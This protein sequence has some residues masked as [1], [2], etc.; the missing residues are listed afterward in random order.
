[1]LFSPRGRRAGRANLAPPS[2]FA[3]LGARGF[4]MAPELES[5]RPDE[6]D[7][8]PAAPADNSTTRSPPARRGAP[9]ARA[10]LVAAVVVP[11]A[12]VALVL[13]T[14]VGPARLTVGD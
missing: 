14:S 10:R 5:G 8:R 11:A 7:G 3:P 9:Q 2:P 12:L 6:R 1:M 13:A 4:F